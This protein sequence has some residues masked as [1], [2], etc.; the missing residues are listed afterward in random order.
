M[1]TIEPLFN[2]GST[3]NKF[4][5][6]VRNALKYKQYKT[7]LSLASSKNLKKFIIYIKIIVKCNK[8]LI[9][10]CV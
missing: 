10:Y 3:R 2:S 5:L 7:V 9:I 8:I 6:S 1:Q 4:K